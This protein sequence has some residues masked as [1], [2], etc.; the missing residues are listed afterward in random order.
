MDEA[1]SLAGGGRSCTLATGFE[2]SFFSAC[3]VTR[4]V[5]VFFV[6]CFCFFCKDNHKQQERVPCGLVYV[7]CPQAS[8]HALLH[9]PPPAA[10]V[11]LLVL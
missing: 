1:S 2:S 9:R 11:F 8:D 7:E 3:D 4:C 10:S 6:F 5:F